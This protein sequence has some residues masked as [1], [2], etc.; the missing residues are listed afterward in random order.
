MYD[1]KLFDYGD[2]PLFA[3]ASGSAGVDFGP[4]GAT[5]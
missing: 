5:A 4:I 1:I 2:L 3:S